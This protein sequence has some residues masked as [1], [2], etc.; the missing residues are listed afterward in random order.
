[1][2]EPTVKH[3]A[4]G[5]RAE[6]GLHAMTAAAMAVALL[7]SA[8]SKS[9]ADETAPLPQS[10]FDS[11]AVTY[12]SDTVTMR[13]VGPANA[14][15]FPTGR[16]N[17]LRGQFKS[18]DQL[19]GRWVRGADQDE[20]WLLTDN[21]YYVWY[22][23][24]AGP[25]PDPSYAPPIEVR[26]RAKPVVANTGATLIQDQDRLERLIDK[27][28]NEAAPN[29]VIAEMVRANVGYV[30]FDVEGD[31][32]LKWAMCAD[33]CESEFQ[34]TLI[35]Q[36]ERPTLLCIHQQLANRG[37]TVWYSDRRLLR[38][39]PGLCPSSLSAIE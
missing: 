27:K 25:G 9:G 32:S 21:G 14:R 26:Q 2:Q 38:R 4:S 17:T 3:S 35:V 33:D 31:R 39:T 34:S 8:C 1:M 15:S 37:T 22:G 18:G 12:L 16:G 19:R 10:W 13:V 7:L 6:G 24:L 11:Y 20:H 5:N 29:S 30:R 23:N 36:A 28:L